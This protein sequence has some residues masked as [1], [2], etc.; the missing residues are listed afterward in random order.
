MTSQLSR[1]DLREIAYQ[2]SFNE[3]EREL[4][5]MLL[6]GMDSEP[7][8]EVIER[9]CS[10]EMNT[11]MTYRRVKGLGEMESMPVGTKFYTA[12]PASVVKHVDTIALHQRVDPDWCD[13]YMQGY[14]NSEARKTAPVDVPDENGLLSCAFCGGNAEFDYDDHNLTWI[15]CGVC[16]V[17]TD[18]AYQTD[19]DARDKLL[20]VWNRRASMLKAGPVTAATVPEGW[21][22]VPVE[23]TKRMVIDGFESEP[24]EMFS[25]PEVWEAYQAM[26]GCRQAAH[27]ARLCY[28]AMLAAAP[29]APEQE[30]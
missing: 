21:K 19:V 3:L 27:R 25:E 6:G 2:G 9:P 24:D 7:V 16:G 28:A 12:P 15:S 20:E 30:V 5:R 13:A 22:L 29:V 26:S 11:G 14:H 8:G 18:T 4:A 17:S 23:P 10:G 1:E